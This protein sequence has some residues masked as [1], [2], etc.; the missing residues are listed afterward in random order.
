MRT[1]L[2][3]AV[4][5][6]ASPAAFAEPVPHTITVDGDAEVYVDPDHAS[7]DL[8]VETVAPTVGEA[9]AQNN[10]KMDRVL[11]ALRGSG[12]ARNEIQTSSFSITPTH[13]Q[14]K[15]GNY[16]YNAISGYQVTNKLT[17][18]L[19]D[20]AKVGPVIDAAANAGASS[21]SNVAFE[22]KD[23][24]ALLDKVR[25]EAM[26]NARHKAEIMAGA[27][28]S[29]VGPLVSVGNRFV[30]EEREYAPPPPPPPPP[31]PPPGTSILPGQLSVSAHVTAAFALN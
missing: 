22:L 16:D 11:A 26:R 19:S 24:E 5:A 31:L 13:P 15:D 27:V 6:L 9:L 14:N 2:F 12:V 30:S 23:R 1:I 10:A 28:G 17:V 21:S 4:M 7:V 8:G 3:A 18:T 29:H 25:A 20:I